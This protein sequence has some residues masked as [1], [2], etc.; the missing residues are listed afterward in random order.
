MLAE[1]AMFSLS[2]LPAATEYANRDA[3]K[4]VRQNRLS[5]ML[6][7]CA[8]WIVQSAQFRRE[9]VTPSALVLWRVLMTDETEMVDKAIERIIDEMSDRHFIA[10]R[11]CA[12]QTELGSQA[13][14][15]Y[16]PGRQFRL[17]AAQGDRRS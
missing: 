7:E 1:H 9:L 14:E 2:H 15:A 10:A 8:L 4:N 11:V 13:G 6:A 17:D 5:E 12:V 16:R 3:L